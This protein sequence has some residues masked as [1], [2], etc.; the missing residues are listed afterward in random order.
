MITEMERICKLCDCPEIQDV[1][2]KLD[3]RKVCIK[4]RQKLGAYEELCPICADEGNTV[5]Q[6]FIWLL[7]IDQ[8]LEMLG[9]KFVSLMYDTEYKLWNVAYWRLKKNYLIG[10]ESARLALLRAVKECIK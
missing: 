7:T 6:S 9:D 2:K 8:L 4:H 1:A 10:G 5:Q 3:C